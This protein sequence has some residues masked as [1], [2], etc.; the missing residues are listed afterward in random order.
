MNVDVA[1]SVPESLVVV[2][3][4]TAVELA[5]A[6]NTDSDAI[7]AAGSEKTPIEE[8]TVDDAESDVPAADV[9]DAADAVLEAEDDPLAIV[10]DAKDTERDPLAP[11][12]PS[13]PSPSSRSP[14]SPC[15]PK[16]SDSPEAASSRRP[17]PP[18]G[19]RG[20]R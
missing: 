12:E 14:A 17:R 8:V 15:S 19:T 10:L 13:A 1:M 6:V 4:E 3:A 20:P 2:E 9:E 11:T 16:A 5:E 7:L 18:S